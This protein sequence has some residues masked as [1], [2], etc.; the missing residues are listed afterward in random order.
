MNRKYLALLLVILFTL[1]IFNNTIVAEND[2][3]RIAMIR[4]LLDNEE[5]FD[6]ND[7]ENCTDVVDY[8]EFI[9][10]VKSDE[11]SDKDKFEFLDN[12]DI[13]SIIDNEDYSKLLEFMGNG[14]K[15]VKNVHI[16]LT[17]RGLFMN[18][19]IRLVKL[20]HPFPRLTRVGLFPPGMIN[21]YIFYINITHEKY[22][23][24][25]NDSITYNASTLIE[26]ENGD[27]PIYIQGNCSI[28]ALVWQ[29]AP[30]NKIIGLKR[31]LVKWYNLVNGL[32]GPN[33]TIA[34]FPWSLE[35]WRFQN[36]F[37]WLIPAF[38]HNF[39]INIG[40]FSFTIPGFIPSTYLEFMFMFM[41][42]PF[43]VWISFLNLKFYGGISG[44]APFVIYNTGNS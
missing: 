19:K 31:K 36:M 38:P 1:T 41:V 13:D 40:N 28:L 34:T 33:R 24:L 18:K 9:E 30:I 44:M 14:S 39:S 27:P 6:I 21:A 12:S 32:K 11:F 15:L 8:N 43:N 2:N 17:G 23:D 16:N 37:N 29:I 3:N 4:D 42:W 20:V 7:I 26:P 5:N 22:T 25:Y 35:K 10:F